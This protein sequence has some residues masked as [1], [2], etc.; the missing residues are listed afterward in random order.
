[1]TMESTR[2]IQAL[3]APSDLIVA[4]RQIASDAR[5]AGYVE[6]AHLA[7]VALLA[8]EEAAERDLVLRRKV[9]PA[10]VAAAA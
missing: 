2:D 8:A 10:P 6:V 7:S 5:R 3:P 4:L 9:V 1:M